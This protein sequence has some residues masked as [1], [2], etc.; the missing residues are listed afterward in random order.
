[1]T[2]LNKPELMLAQLSTSSLIRF[3]GATMRPTKKRWLS[4]ALLEDGGNEQPG[5]FSSDTQ[6]NLPSSLC[7][8]PVGQ[9]SLFT[10][11]ISSASGLAALTPHINPKKRLISQFSC[12]VTSS[13]RSCDHVDSI[14]SSDQAKAK[15]EFTTTDISS[16]TDPTS[17]LSVNPI[18]SKATEDHL[19]ALR[20]GNY[21]PTPVSGRSEPS[22]VDQ[23]GQFDISIGPSDASARTTVVPTSSLH[24]SARLVDNI[25]NGPE[26]A[27]STQITR[28]SQSHDDTIDEPGISHNVISM[29][30]LNHHHQLEETEAGLFERIQH[31]T[32]DLQQFQEPRSSPID[33]PRERIGKTE[34][35]R[36]QKS[37][38]S[39][40]LP[41]K[42][43][44]L[45]RQQEEQRLQEMR[46]VRV[47][48]HEYRRRRGLA[49]LPSAT[50][51]TNTCSNMSNRSHLLSS[52]N[53]DLFRFEAD[54][55]KITLDCL[56][57]LN[58]KNPYGLMTLASSAT[59]SLGAEGHAKID[60]IHS[61]Q[62]PRSTPLDTFN[63]QPPQSS[64]GLFLVSDQLETDQSSP[65][66]SL[67]RGELGR[68]TSVLRSR[69]SESLSELELEAL[70]CPIAMISHSS[71]QS[72]LPI[73]ETAV[74]SAQDP[75]PCPQQPPATRAAANSSSSSSSSSSSWASLPGGKSGLVTSD[76]LIRIS[77][78]LDVKLTHDRPELLDT[79]CVSSAAIDPNERG[80]RTPSEPSDQEEADDDDEEA[81]IINGVK[82]ARHNR[83][84]KE[85]NTYVPS[86]TIETSFGTTL[87]SDSPRPVAIA[88]IETDLTG[89]VATAKKRDR[90]A[91]YPPNGLSAFEYDERRSTKYR[92]EESGQSNGPSRPRSP[93]DSASDIR[94]PSTCSSALALGS[95]RGALEPVMDEAIIGGKLQ[96]PSSHGSSPP[97]PVSEASNSPAARLGC[98]FGS[99]FV[100]GTTITRSSKSS[101]RSRELSAVKLH[102]GTNFSDKL[103]SMPLQ[104]P[105]ASIPPPPPP[106]PT[107]SLLLPPPPPPPPLCSSAI[108]VGPNSEPDVKQS[109]PLSLTASAPHS[110]RDYFIRRDKEIQAWQERTTLQ[111]QLAKQRWRLPI[112]HHH[113]NQQHQHHPHLL[114]AT[115]SIPPPQLL[116]PS[117]QSTRPPHLPLPPLNTSLPP[118]HQQLQQF[119][120]QPQQ[121][122][123]TPQQTSVLSTGINMSQ[124]YFCSLR[125]LDGAAKGGNQPLL[126]QPHQCD[127]IR[128]RLPF[129]PSVSSGINIPPCL[130]PG[131]P[132]ASKLSPNSGPILSS[133]GFS[134]RTQ[135]VSS[136]SCLPSKSTIFSSLPPP[137]YRDVTLLHSISLPNSSSPP[138]PLPIT[139]PPSLSLPL[140]LPPPPPPPPPPSLSIPPSL[141]QVPPPPPPPPPPQPSLPLPLPLPLNLP[142]P[143]LPSLDKVPG[144]IQLLDTSL[145]PHPSFLSRIWE[146]RPPT[147]RSSPL[148]SREHKPH[149]RNYLSCHF[150]D[151]LQT[152]RNHS[153]PQAPNEP[154]GSQYPGDSGFRQRHAS[155]EAR[156]DRGLSVQTTCLS[157]QLGVVSSPSIGV[158]ST[159]PPQLSSAATNIVSII[160]GA[161]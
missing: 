156:V 124:P 49:S 35:D 21:Q 62:L 147:G 149:E 29:S 8:T 112:P 44:T 34:R 10:C 159:P 55:S 116:Q 14:V 95:W 97:S 155:S 103:M 16:N 121:Q 91:F 154:S 19:N 11:P 140:P 100:P 2:G 139:H 31:I 106:L 38:E 56:P 113:H 78:E 59:L 148:F 96:L 72:C 130:N 41:P 58:K 141:L 101:L 64:V 45:K 86:K 132:L 128:T 161:I 67:L 53:V 117:P 23:I 122:K 24:R 98:D 74:S 65:H 20:S 144:P 18:T 82:S 119:Q 71:P 80:P 135:H 92:A 129:E 81:I 115:H 4:Q 68:P 54:E 12:S 26:A 150:H 36:Q 85:S 93:R 66:G 33:K 105:L 17:G 123:Q 110:A 39:K 158:Y 138:P 131:T 77:T 47:S 83:I 57:R 127:Q 89:L 90:D 28:A 142:P 118:Q 146:H 111:H 13:P 153:F 143:G 133:P 69:T 15:L 22:Q 152:Q 52:L 87:V 63:L 43:A 94:P 6:L 84:V 88:G 108:V 61:P 50:G 42:K 157:H 126:S 120:P 134:H 32:A 136:G 75:P 3:T 51:I 27:Q 37:A 48:L 137:S 7:L 60:A 25:A 104:L 40:K 1:M 125:M 5:C 151:Q 73:L 102:S 109:S 70:P 30:Y 79:G 9:S 76:M 114:V 46:K 107:S 145:P 160:T 99:T